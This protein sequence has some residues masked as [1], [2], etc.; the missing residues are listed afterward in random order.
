MTKEI[1]GLKGGDYLCFPEWMI[2]AGE[3]DLGRGMKVGRECGRGARCRHC[4]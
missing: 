2:A 3:F 4:R 1:M